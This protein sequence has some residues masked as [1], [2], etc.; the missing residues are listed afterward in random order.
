MKHFCFWEGVHRLV[1]GIQFIS[2]LYIQGDEV[3]WTVP[4][5]TWS[6]L[7]WLSEE[8]RNLAWLPKVSEHPQTYN[9]QD[10]SLAKQSI[11]PQLKSMI[12]SLLLDQPV[13]GLELR[14]HQLSISMGWARI[15][16][17]R[18]VMNP[19]FTNHTPILINQELRI[20]F[21]PEETGC[22]NLLCPMQGKIF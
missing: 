5:S 1:L 11:G 15:S 20:L 3:L 12:G 21:Y 22:C 2:L 17:T 13:E 7:C 18:N 14:I 10:V 4:L 8:P 16:I 9:L 6:S 19:L